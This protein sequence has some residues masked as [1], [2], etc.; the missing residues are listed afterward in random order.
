MPIGRC[1]RC[2]WRAVAGSHS[3]MTRLY[4]DHLRA[5]HPKAW[6]RT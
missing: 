6:L 1:T 5:E 4:Q 3:K 2:D